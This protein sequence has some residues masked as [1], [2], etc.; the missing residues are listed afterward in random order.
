MLLRA[1][2]TKLETE[3]VVKP[4]PNIPLLRLL[5][6]LRVLLALVLAA[7]H[8]APEARLLATAANVS[9]S[10]TAG[11]SSLVLVRL[12]TLLSVL[13]SWSHCSDRLG[14]L[15]LVSGIYNTRDTCQH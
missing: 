1:S 6:V 9:S 13:G 8:V 3:L 14:T 12:G 15:T 10:D 4:R 11:D 7:E 2:L 5:A